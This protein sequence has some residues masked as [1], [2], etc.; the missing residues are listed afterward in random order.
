MPISRPSP[1]RGS[2]PGLDLTGTRRTGDTLSE[3]WP[4]K[5]KD[6]LALAQSDVQ[7]AYHR[8]PAILHLHSLPGPLLREMPDEEGA[9]DVLHVQEMPGEHVQ[10]PALAHTCWTILLFI[11]DSDLCSGNP[12]SNRPGTR[13]RRPHH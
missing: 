10:P 7:C 5:T 13:H 12:G 8:R 11:Y 9:A 4:R 2:R 6:R 1:I 3:S